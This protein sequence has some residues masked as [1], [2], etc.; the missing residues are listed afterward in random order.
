MAAAAPGESD[1]EIRDLGAFLTWLLPFA[2]A[3]VAH[4]EAHPRYYSD[5]LGQDIQ[6]RGHLALKAI[7]A[8]AL[9]L[10]CREEVVAEYLANLPEG[11]HSI[12]G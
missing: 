5:A 9:H 4:G 1:W 8:G 11:D 3:V 12:G 6:A 10:G 2:A 7:A